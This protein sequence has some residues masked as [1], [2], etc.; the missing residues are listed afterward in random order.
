MKNITIPTYLLYTLIVAILLISVIFFFAMK[1]GNKC[2]GNPLVY[3][4]QKASTSDSGDITC[5]CSFS[6]PSYAPFYFDKNNMSVM[7]NLIG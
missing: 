5:S 3:G 7:N 1:D 4:A 6:N 2:I